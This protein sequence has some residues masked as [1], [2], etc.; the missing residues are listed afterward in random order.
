MIILFWTELRYLLS[1]RVKVSTGNS[2]S[3]SAEILLFFPGRKIT[4][5]PFSGSSFPVIKI[6]AK[7]NCGGKFDTLGQA[8]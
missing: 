5:I 1:G 8:R 4:G 2:V 6:S 7:K 3:V